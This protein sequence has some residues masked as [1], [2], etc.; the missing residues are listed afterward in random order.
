MQH[1]LEGAVEA[2]RDYYAAL[3]QGR[4]DGFTALERETRRATDANPWGASALL[5]STTTRKDAIEQCLT[6]LPPP[7]RP[8]AGPHGQALRTLADATHTQPDAVEEI[9]CVLERRLIRKRRVS[10]TYK[11]LSLVFF[12]L[13]RGSSE[14]VDR[15]ND[16]R[17]HVADLSSMQWFNA[18]GKELGASVRV[19]AEE[20]HSLLSSR[21]K[22]TE[23]RQTHAKPLTASASSEAAPRRQEASIADG[24]TVHA[25]PRKSDLP[26]T[27]PAPPGPS[28]SEREPDFQQRLGQQL[29]G[30]L[31][32]QE[33]R[34]CAD[35]GAQNPT[36]ASA[37]LGLFV[38]MR[39]SGYHR[40]LGV[41]ISYVK[42]TKLDA[43][44]QAQVDVVKQV[45]NHA[46]NAYWEA[47]LEES[48]AELNLHDSGKLQCFIK[49]KYQ[50]RRYAP[51]DALPPPLQRSNEYDSDDEEENQK[52]HDAQ[53]QERRAHSP[54][55][56]GKIDPFEDDFIRLAQQRETS[57][58]S[59]F[60]DDDGGAHAF[61]DTSS[62]A[63]GSATQNASAPHAQPKA[64]SDGFEPAFEQPLKAERRPGSEHP[65]APFQPSFDNA[66]SSS[67]PARPKRFNTTQRQD[68]QQQ[69]Q[70]ASRSNPPPATSSSTDD[71]LID[72]VPALKEDP[73]DGNQA[74]QQHQEAGPPAQEDA[75]APDLLDL[76]GPSTGTEA[77]PFA[78]DDAL[79]HGAASKHRQ[80]QKEPSAV[81]LS[82]SQA[83]SFA[84]EPDARAAFCAGLFASGSSEQ[85]DSLRGEHMPAAP[86]GDERESNVDA[87]LSLYSQKPQPQQHPQMPALHPQETHLQQQQQ[88]RH[89]SASRRLWG[90]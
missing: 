19:K 12:L 47:Q 87:I 61:V 65:F 41:H 51:A 50:E 63:F 15:A 59:D 2:A 31:L 48:K 43:W 45:G 18:E 71:P 37:N 28:Q 24:Q 22:L 58:K 85:P 14:C 62:R 82:S 86:H 29:K 4:L 23:Q 56:S 1:P 44:S 76:S 17:E 25:G 40:G 35:C 6:P 77:N 83:K 54:L 81:L 16:L 11:A 26:S 46:A 27:P 89:M 90:V 78:D 73:T 7:S 9:F 68:H 74:G 52:H 8:S 38:C 42:S 57:R 66:E 70:A 72:L 88:A 60:L 10:K 34:S 3:R 49:D 69:Q 39:C 64:A 13:T 32:R 80:Q 75:Q 36:W 67:D 55:P 20:I 33:N 21:H 84:K 30:L 5:P 79:P 53:Q